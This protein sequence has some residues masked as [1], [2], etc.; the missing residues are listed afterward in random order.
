MHLPPPNGITLGN[1]KVF[2]ETVSKCALLYEEF[3]ALMTTQSDYRNPVAENG[4]P[5]FVEPVQNHNN[6][7]NNN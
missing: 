6:P 7:F 1:V 2:P 4:A 5:L 3:E